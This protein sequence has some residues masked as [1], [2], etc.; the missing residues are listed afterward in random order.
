KNIQNAASETTQQYLYFQSQTTGFMSRCRV[1]CLRFFGV[2]AL[3]RAV[4]G[5]LLEKFN[6]NAVCKFGRDQNA[7]SK[8]ARIRLKLMF[9]L[10]SEQAACGLKTS[11]FDAHAHD[12]LGASFR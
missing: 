9:C 6:P 11:A 8:R 1:T 12:P 10:R 5:S 3:A 7:L 4:A 2:A